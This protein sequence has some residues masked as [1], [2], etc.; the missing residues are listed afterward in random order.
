MHANMLFRLDDTEQDIIG[1]TLY[2]Q[3]NYLNT[4]AGTCRVRPGK[5]IDS[6]AFR[7][8]R[9]YSAI[10][11]IQGDSGNTIVSS[12]YYDMLGRQVAAPLTG[13]LYIEHTTYTDGTTAVRKIIR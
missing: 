8:V 9:D 4:T 11:T 6:I 12:T 10:D 13:T 1:Q 3:F 2:V 5:Y 7:L